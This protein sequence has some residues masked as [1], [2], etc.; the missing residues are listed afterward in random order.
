MVERLEAVKE[1]ELL[2]VVNRCWAVFRWSKYI[3]AS[4]PVV[5]IR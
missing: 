1:A 4:W 5:K 2:S 3:S